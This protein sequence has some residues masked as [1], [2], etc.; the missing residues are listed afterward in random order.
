MQFAVSD[1]QQII[2]LIE[3]F[4]LLKEEFLQYLNSII[5]SGNVPGLY[6][7]QEFEQ[8][9]HVLQKLALEESYEEDLQSYFS[10]SLFL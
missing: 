8:I 5:V 3:D 2:L 1:N 6:S 10:Y 9:I 4:N 7:I